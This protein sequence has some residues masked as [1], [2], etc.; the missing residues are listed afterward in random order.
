MSG[1]V[2]FSKTCSKDIIPVHALS[3]TDGCIFLV[4]YKII[5]SI[6]MILLLSTHV[7]YLLA[8]SKPY[9]IHASVAVKREVLT[10]T[11]EKPSPRWGH[12]C[13]I[14]GDQLYVFGGY[15]TQLHNDLYVLN[16]SM[17]LTFDEVMLFM[18]CRH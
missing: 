9:L 18:F 16:L 3:I 2:L 11:G 10:T 7:S 8:I 5:V 15:G 6:Q 1:R 14:Y 17:C 13:A 4:E 12:S